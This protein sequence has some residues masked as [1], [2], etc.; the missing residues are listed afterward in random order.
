MCQDH[1]IKCEV[2]YCSQDFFLQD[3]VALTACQ[4]ACNKYCDMVITYFSKVYM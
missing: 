2:C 4:E 3:N 1:M